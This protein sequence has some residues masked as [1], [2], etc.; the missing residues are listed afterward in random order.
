MLRAGTSAKAF[1]SHVAA[2]VCPVSLP[3]LILCQKINQEF[4]ARL[5]CNEKKMIFWHQQ[6]T[7]IELSALSYDWN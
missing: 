2:D 4:D 6:G 3:S 5:R 7:K 1:Q